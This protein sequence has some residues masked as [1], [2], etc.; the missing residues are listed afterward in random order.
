MTKPVE[1]RRQ[2]G[3]VPKCADNT[4]A[5]TDLSA[6]R[7]IRLYNILRTYLQLRLTAS[8]SE[9]TGQLARTAEHVIESI[10]R[11]DRGD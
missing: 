6:K 1:F 8:H 11:V 3:E 9:T 10:R 2:E 5:G 7:D 4:S